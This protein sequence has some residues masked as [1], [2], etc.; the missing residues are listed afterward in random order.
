VQLFNRI[1]RIRRSALVGRSVSPG[2][3][4]E[5]FKAHLVFLSFFWR[6]EK[7]VV[8]Q[9]FSSIMPRMPA[10]HAPYQDSNG[11]NCM[12]ASN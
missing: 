5:T 11:L 6:K 9:D 1:R 10:S 8:P 12:E 2:V 4:L 7:E 3:G